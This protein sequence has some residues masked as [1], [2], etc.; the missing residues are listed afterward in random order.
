MWKRRLIATVTFFAG[1]YYFLE[2]I[3]PATIPWSTVS[4]VVRS[5]S[6]S[7]VQVGLVRKASAVK[8]SKDTEILRAVNGGSRAQVKLDALRPGDTVEIAEGARRIAAGVVI[9]RTPTRVKL[10]RVYSTRSVAVKESRTLILRKRATG[11]PEQVPATSL[12]T[13]DWISVGPKTYLSGALV[14]VNRFFIILASL[15]WGMGLFSL[16]IVHT[17]NIRKKRPEWGLSLVF[18]IAVIGG[19]IA[20]IGYGEPKGWWVW[21]KPANSVIF[22]S[23]IRPMSSTVF[24]LLTFYL[25]S[26]S[27]RSF[28]A[29]SAEAILMMVSAIIVM[30]GQIP[31]GLWLTHWLQGTPVEFL[32]IPALG[33]WILR[34]LNSAAVR[35][36]W[37]GMM[38]GA[39]AVGLRFWLSL[40]RGAFFDREL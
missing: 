20:G 28:R 7:T 40:E 19:I 14:T 6:D 4:G 2:F 39:V 10:G 21:A 11:A 27:Y 22:Y 9:S 5:V 37:F 32:Q 25:A 1:L 26:A 15:A 18:F 29:K 30:L 33:Q 38:L 16:W 31:I 35:G 3:V 17:S 36:L 24:S 12:K 23:M 8:I 34:T 13:G